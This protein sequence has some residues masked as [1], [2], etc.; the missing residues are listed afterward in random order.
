MG[1]RHV[2]A[3]LGAVVLA[4]VLS[5]LSIAVEPERAGAA[6]TVETCGGISITLNAQE[7]RILELHN[8]A[9]EDHGL[10]SLCVDLR[11][12]MAARSHSRE[13]IEK[14]YFSHASYDGEGSSARLGSFGYDCGICV[15]NIAG[16]Y[17]TLGEPD[18]TF[19]RW[20]DSAHHRGNILDDT[21]RRVGVGTDTGTYKG[22]E[23]YT[24]YTVDFGDQR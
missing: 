6:T 10:E 8:E 11:L 4:G 15:E 2:V 17:G 9:R 18:P 21:F 16:G 19:E 23:G 5:L 24:M 20:M 3:F 14:D 13:M 1:S 22:I 12:T 7:R